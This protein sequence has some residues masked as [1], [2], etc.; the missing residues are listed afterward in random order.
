MQIFVGFT[1]F[2]RRYIFHYSILTAPITDLPKGMRNGKK[3]GHFLFTREAREAFR[4][5]EAFKKEPLLRHFDPLKPLRLESDASL[6]AAGVVLSQPWDDNDGMPLL[7]TPVAFWSFKFEP[8]ER[9]NG[10]PDQE[11]LAIVRA[12]RHWRQYLESSRHPVEVP[13]DH[14][15][16]RSFMQ[17]S[18]KVAQSRHVRRIEL[19]AGFDFEIIYRTGKTNSADGPSRRPDYQRC[20]EDIGLPTYWV[21]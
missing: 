13:T 15:N 6:F 3:T 18:T 16:L 5:L 21:K 10:T 7:A 20:E 12:F 14:V 8:G 1:D 2:Y 19:F 11:N 4:K 17:P 9:H